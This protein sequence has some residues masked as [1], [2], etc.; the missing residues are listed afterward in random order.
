MSYISVR[1]PFVFCLVSSTVI[2]WRHNSD[3]FERQPM[4]TL[5][6]RR[7]QKKGEKK[8]LILKM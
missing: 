7:L 6:W 8:A 3:K 2:Q 4:S 1:T 5:M